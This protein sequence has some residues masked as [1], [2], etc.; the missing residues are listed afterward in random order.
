[1]AAS[2]KKRSLSAKLSEL[3]GESAAKKRTKNC[4]IQIKQLGLEQEDILVKNREI[5][6]LK[7]DFFNIDTISLSRAL[8]GN[9]KS[10]LLMFC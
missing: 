3:V 2:G 7:N 9:I 8:L 5:N 6:C 1:M 4:G 10:L